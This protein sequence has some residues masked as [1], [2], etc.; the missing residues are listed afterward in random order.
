MKKTFLLLIAGLFFLN[1]GC[2]YF[3]APGALRGFI[4]AAESRDYTRM[5]DMLKEKNFG[6]DT[7]RS[8]QEKEKMLADSEFVRNAVS[9]V[10]STGISEKAELNEIRIFEVSLA[11]KA[12]GAQ[13]YIFEMTKE[14][15]KWLI[16]GWFDKKNYCR[17]PHPACE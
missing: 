4:N 2:S 8:T 3:G 15:G 12:G 14:N 10:T 9:G 13:S 5:I 11:T 17:T 16:H 1:A 6:K 7:N